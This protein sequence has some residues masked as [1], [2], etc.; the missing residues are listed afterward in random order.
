MDFSKNEQKSEVGDALRVSIAAL[1]APSNHSFQGVS[2]A[3]FKCQAFLKINP[4]GRIP[5]LIDRE[6][7]VSV[8]ESGAILEYAP[9]RPFHRS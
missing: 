7:Q 9:W 4:N 3:L 8:A 1:N 6:K 2:R 5:A